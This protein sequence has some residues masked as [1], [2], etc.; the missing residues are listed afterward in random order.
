MQKHPGKYTGLTIDRLCYRYR[1]DKVSACSAGSS[2]ML[3]LLFLSGGSNVMHKTFA[4]VALGAT[5]ALVFNKTLSGI[6]NTILSPL[7][8]TYA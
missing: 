3:S 2:S 4:A 6:L 8:L 5:I 1:L 7:G